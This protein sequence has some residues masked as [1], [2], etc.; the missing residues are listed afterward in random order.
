M[1]I[2]LIKGKIHMILSFYLVSP[3]DDVQRVLLFLGYYWKQV[4]V[5]CCGGGGCRGGCGRCLS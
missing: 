4:W 2:V 1:F 3:A 5:F